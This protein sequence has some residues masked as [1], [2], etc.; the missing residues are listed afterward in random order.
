MHGKEQES[1]QSVILGKR[2]E[3]NQHVQKQQHI[4]CPERLS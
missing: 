3:F 2:W 4:I 1:A